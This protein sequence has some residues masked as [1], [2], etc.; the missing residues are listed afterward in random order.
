MMRGKVFAPLDKVG[1]ASHIRHGNCG[2]GWTGPLSAESSGWRGLSGGTY[3]SGTP[4]SLNRTI[5][6]V[7][8]TASAGAPSYKATRIWLCCAI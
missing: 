2:E 4:S 5:W 7:P 8:P 6:A 3:R 1:L